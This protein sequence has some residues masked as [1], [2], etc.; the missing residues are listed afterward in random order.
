MQS[1]IPVSPI[2]D[3]SLRSPA[4]TRRRRWRQGLD[5]GVPALLLA[6]RR[7][8]E[9]AMGCRTT[10]AHRVRFTRRSCASGSAVS[11]SAVRRPGT[12][13]GTASKRC[14]NAFLYH[15]LGSLTLGRL[16]LHDAGYPGRAGCGKA[17]GPAGDPRIGSGS[18]RDAVRH[19]ALLFS[20]RDKTSNT[21]PSQIV[22]TGPRSRPK[23]D[24]ALKGVLRKERGG[25]SADHRNAGWQLVR[26]SGTWCR[27]DD[28]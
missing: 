7:V 18:K 25:R 3:P 16:A 5:A 20:S 13:P 11:G 24:T 1:P 15:R 28:R 21:G 19:Y 10:P 23:K 22:G 2:I 8:H 14:S 6:H 26:R 17:A 4:K 27:R 12:L 9:P